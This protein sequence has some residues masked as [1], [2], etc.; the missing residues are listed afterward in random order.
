MIWIEDQNGNLYYCSSIKIKIITSNQIL[1]V[2]QNGE[3]L[4][5]Y[6]DMARANKVL[7]AIK[8]VII[9]NEVKIFSMPKKFE[10]PEE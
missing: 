4:G 9:Y 5:E 8:D 1:I 2:N 6:F 7:K 3:T 10:I